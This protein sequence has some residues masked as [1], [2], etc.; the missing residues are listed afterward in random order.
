MSYL[1]FFPADHLIGDYRIGPKT[2]TQNIANRN[3]KK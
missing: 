2:N 1:I 3:K